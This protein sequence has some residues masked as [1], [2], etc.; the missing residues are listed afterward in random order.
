MGSKPVRKRIEQVIEIINDRNIL[1]IVT[2]IK[3]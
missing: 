1:K 3:S 2:L